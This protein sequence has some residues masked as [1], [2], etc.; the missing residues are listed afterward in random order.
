VRAVVRIFSSKLDMF[1]NPWIGLIGVAL[2]AVLGGAI[3]ILGEPLKR[4]LVRR[5]EIE[6]AKAEMYD[7]IAEYVALLQNADKGAF[8]NY[9]WLRTNN[10]ELAMIRWYKENRMDLLLTIDKKRGLRRIYN[11]FSD[12]RELQPLSIDII[13]RLALV[14]KLAD[15][16]Y[17]DAAYLRERV[18]SA[19]ELLNGI[20]EA[21][22][23]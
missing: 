10:P 2:G 20:H 18:E 5:S 23:S 22:Q 11:I 13:G 16:R 6:H 14:R 17:L 15:R 7:D 3:S 21:A 4:R 1:E 9:R 8:R 12:D 19:T